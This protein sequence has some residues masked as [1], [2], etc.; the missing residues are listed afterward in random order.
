[1]AA[2]DSFQDSAQDAKAQIAHLR[3]QVESLMADRV[4][5][6]LAGAAGRVEETARHASDYASEQAEMLSD[7]VKEQPLIAILVA[8][9]VG[10]LLGRLSA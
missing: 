9:G 8:V 6:A 1:M 2:S 7:R 4:T 10:F 5:P 3:R